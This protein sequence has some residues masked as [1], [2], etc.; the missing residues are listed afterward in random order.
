MTAAHTITAELDDHGTP[1]LIR[2]ACTGGP[3]DNCHQWC[4]EGC[5]EFCY[6]SPERK[7]QP[8][9]TVIVTGHHWAPMPPDGRSCRIV[10]W[11][12]ASGAEDTH[13]DEDEPYRPGTHPITAAWDGG[14]YVWAYAEAPR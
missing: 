8:D 3:D 7:P 5:E 10:D 13:A 2:F 1:D 9:G 14:D 4:T 12:D 6:A 11:L